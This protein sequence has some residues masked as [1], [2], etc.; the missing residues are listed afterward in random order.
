MRL[1]CRV[2]PV[3]LFE[4]PPPNLAAL[5]RSWARPRDQVFVATGWGETGRIPEPTREYSPEMEA[6]ELFASATSVRV[7]DRKCLLDFVNQWGLLG[8]SEPEEEPK[9]YDSA[10]L[11]SEKLAKFQSLS[12]WL[13]ALKGRQWKSDALL[14]FDEVR[15]MVRGV[16]D[17]ATRSVR[18]RAYWI[19][20]GN[21]L[22]QELFHRK[23]VAELLPGR[24]GLVHYLRVP[25][26]ADYLFITLWRLASEEDQVLRRCPGCE[27][28]FRVRVTNRKKRHCST[29]CKA[30]LAM[31]KHR[32]KQKRTTKRSKK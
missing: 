12:N 25:T 19:A 10:V 8:V 20:F 13:A 3:S 27:G 18:R 26:L 11:T 29:Q 14:P 1:W 21:M 6:E 5:R 30:R 17:P 4:S 23:L 32:A 28:L 2:Y 16:P 22:N 7:Q 15:K 31:R 24:V 9:I